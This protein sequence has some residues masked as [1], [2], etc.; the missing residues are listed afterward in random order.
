MSEDLPATLPDD[1]HM[2]DLP[3]W[4]RPASPLC[5]GG[6]SQA[7]WEWPRPSEGGI[8]RP[9]AGQTLPLD[10]GRTS[11]TFCCDPERR[12][13]AFDACQASDFTRRAYDLPK[14]FANMPLSL[15][16]GGVESKREVP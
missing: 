5:R 16:T 11:R 15:V 6:R 3:S 14:G 2:L 4:G 7:V 8:T 10:L 1:N 12:E 13:A 9:R